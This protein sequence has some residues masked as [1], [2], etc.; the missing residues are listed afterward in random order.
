MFFYTFSS[1]LNKGGKSVILRIVRRIKVK[2]LYGK[3]SVPSDQSALNNIRG[4]K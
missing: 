2:I 1:P 3:T 4:K